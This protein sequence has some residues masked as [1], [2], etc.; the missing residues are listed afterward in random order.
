MTRILIVLHALNA[1]IGIL[2]IAVLGLAAHAIIVKDKVD[3]VLPRDVVSTGLGMLMWAGCG[4]V[5]D[6]VFLLGLIST[7]EFRQNTVCWKG[8]CVRVF[9][10]I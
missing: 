10:K 5:V 1:S 8:T 9:D 2:C 6:M 7:R 4:G 3:R